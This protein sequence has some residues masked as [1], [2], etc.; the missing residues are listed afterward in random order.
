[1]LNDFVPPEWIILAAGGFFTLGYLIINQVILR[2]MILSGTM[3]YIWYYAVVADT[4]LWAAIYTSVAMGVANMIGLSSLFWRNSP[5]AIPVAH[6]DIY[7]QFNDL[8]PGDFRELILRARRITLETDTEITREG[9]ALR[10]LYYV[11]SGRIDIEKRGETFSMPAGV[12]VG[13][14]AF[15]AHQPSAATT[16]LAAGA[17]VLEWDVDMLRNRAARKSRFKLALEAMISRDLA[18]KVSFAVAPR[19]GAWQDDAHRVRA[20]QR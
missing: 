11:I 10:S 5:L 6:R 18:L 9:A 15:L 2:L 17:E 12:F 13:E 16:R 7:P 3:L 1:M 19:Q 20:T 4:P 14:V 8:P